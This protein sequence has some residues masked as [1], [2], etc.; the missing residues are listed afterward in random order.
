MTSQCVAGPLHIAGTTLNVGRLGFGCARL[1]AG[2]EMRMCARLIETALAA[3][4]RHFDTAPAYGQSEDVLGNVLA[5]IPD[6]TLATKIGIPRTEGTP[7]PLSVLYRRTVKPVLAHTPRFKAVLLGLR[8]RRAPPQASTR[9]I[10]TR[11]EIVSSLEDS[12]RRLRRDKVDLFLVH[13]P[14]DFQVDE[15]VGAVMAELQRSGTIGAF[16]LAWD[17][18]V[19]APMYFGQVIQ[20]RYDKSVEGLLPADRGLRIFHGVLRYRG[21]TEDGKYGQRPSDR[22]RQVLERNQSAGVIFSA[23]SPTQIRE[24]AE[25]CAGA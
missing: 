12:L 10:L 1:F 13:E 21:K 14:D 25:A 8:R 5:G 23:S 16:G 17:R 24:V 15:E 6:V 18:I 4:I 11:D 9:T 2:S 22:V 19:P 20:S 3:G 7:H